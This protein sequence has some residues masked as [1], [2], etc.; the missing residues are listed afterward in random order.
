MRTNIR[1]SLLPTG[2]YQNKDVIQKQEIAPS[3]NGYKNNNSKLRA[4]HPPELT[5][6]SQNREH[7][8]NEA[9]RRL[10]EQDVL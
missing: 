4:F 3:S 8:E 5:V 2:G 9:K 10:E 6:A 1:P 7:I